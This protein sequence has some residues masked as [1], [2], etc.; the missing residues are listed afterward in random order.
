M[1]KPRT[2]S[3]SRSTKGD[4]RRQ[5]NPKNLSGQREAIKSD[6]QT[7][8]NAEKERWQLIG[9]LFRKWVREALGLPGND[10]GLKLYLDQ[11]ENGFNRTA[12]FD[13]KVKIIA[14]EKGVYPV[15]IRL[16]RTATF[17]ELED[18]KAIFATKTKEDETPQKNQTESENRT[19]K[20]IGKKP[21]TK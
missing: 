3:S 16:N 1:A 18:G 17:V 21:S 4:T 8:L 5:S 15:C 6:F 9:G 11:M 7:Q 2:K 19:S 13:P 20:L 10:Q 12:Q 14:W